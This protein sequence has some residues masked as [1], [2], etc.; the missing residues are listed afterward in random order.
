MKKKWWIGIFILFFLNPTKTV[1]VNNGIVISPPFVDVE[2]KT[3]DSHQEF[4]LTL[5]NNSQ[6]EQTLNFSLVDFGSLDESGGVAFLTAD[7]RPGDRKYALASWLSLEKDWVIIGPHKSQQIKI[8]ILNK[9]SLSSGGHY[10][11]VLATL[12]NDLGGQE[13]VGLNQALATLIYVQKTG[14]EK[15]SLLLKNVEFNQN[16]FN[17]PKLFKLK[18]ENNGNVHLTPRGIVEIKNYQGK[19][20]AKGIVNQNSGIIIPES[21]RIFETKISKT[22]KFLWPGKYSAK[23]SYRFDGKTDFISYEKNFWYIGYEGILV[24]LFISLSISVLIL[25]ILRKYR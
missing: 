11:A 20:I 24:I 6:I 19:I 18:F 9:E 5:T 17:L 14:G 7:N 21:F 22:P 1:A 16:I 25:Y 12:K 2:I 15:K 8:T 23:I 4:N 13:E 10:G 3:N